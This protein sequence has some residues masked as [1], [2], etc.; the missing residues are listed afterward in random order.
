[1]SQV[2]VRRRTRTPW[3][4]TP[5]T[6]LPHTSDPPASSSTVNISAAT[7]E[8][9]IAGE[10][11][12][13]FPTTTTTTS[14]TSTAGLP[15]TT[16]S[17][18]RR[19]RRPRRKGNRGSRR[20]KNQR[21]TPSALSTT[22]ESMYPDDR[23]LWGSM[24]HHHGQREGLDAAGPGSPLQRMIADIRG[25]LTTS[26]ELLT[27]L[28]TSLCSTLSSAGVHERRCWN[29][30][31]YIRSVSSPVSWLNLY[32]IVKR[33]FAPKCCNLSCLATLCPIQAHNFRIESC[34]YYKFG[35]NIPR[36]HVNWHTHFWTEASGQCYTDQLNLPTVD[37]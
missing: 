32:V 5:T 14:V 4:N 31:S 23:A 35:A 37:T 34:S 20:R 27:Q 12:S 36:H 10:Q 6:S 13:Y 30:T 19:T 26:R 11:V 2:V 22:T 16:D 17:R 9:L 33:A 25:K 3:S 18:P 21:R 1:M 8:S 29:G 28:P 15:S 7:N 24:H